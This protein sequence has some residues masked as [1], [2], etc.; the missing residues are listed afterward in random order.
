MNRPNEQWHVQVSLQSPDLSGD[1]WLR[2]VSVVY[3]VLLLTEWL[4][5]S[6]SVPT[7]RAFLPL[8]FN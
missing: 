1:G 2:E 5:V 4:Q 6:N 7:V 3:L 8:I